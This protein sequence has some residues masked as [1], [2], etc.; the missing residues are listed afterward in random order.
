MTL[1]KS[2][3]NTPPVFISSTESANQGLKA[4]IA[5]LIKEHGEHVLLVK[6]LLNEISSLKEELTCSKLSI[7]KLELDIYGP[8]NK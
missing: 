5:H 1:G 3:S 6:S 8:P 2:S 4:T 7:S